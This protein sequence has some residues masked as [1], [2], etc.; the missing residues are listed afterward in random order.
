MPSS[1]VA[2]NFGGSM[3]RWGIIL[4]RRIGIVALA[5]I[6]TPSHAAAADLWTSRTSTFSL[7]GQGHCVEVAARS[8]F[9]FLKGVSYGDVA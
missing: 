5:S 6:L 3:G 1:A 4:M 7:I 8:C 2:S 9:T